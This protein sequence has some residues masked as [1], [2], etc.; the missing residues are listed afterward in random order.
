MHIR[1]AAQADA[2][3]LLREDKHI[4]PEEIRM[5]LSRG[6]YFLAQ[7]DG[8]SIGWLR[9]NLFWDNTPFLNMIYVLEPFR[10]S[11]MGSALLAAWETEMRTAG[12]SMVMTSSLSDEQGQF[13]YRKHCYRDAGALLLPGEAAEIFFV[14]HLK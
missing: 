4:A 12:Y 9:W 5:L 13:F 1:K 11:G 14:K 2:D 8:E 7:Q 6:R 10:R 3:F